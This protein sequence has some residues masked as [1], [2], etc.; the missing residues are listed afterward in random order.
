MQRASCH[1]R[2]GQPA[3]PAGVD[4]E[5]LQCRV[6]TRNIAVAVDMR[7]SCVGAAAAAGRASQ[8]ELLALTARWQNPV[9]E[10]GFVKCA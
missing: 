4:N 1:S 5:Q 6:D 10:K 2:W 3:G 9:V 8:L 7:A